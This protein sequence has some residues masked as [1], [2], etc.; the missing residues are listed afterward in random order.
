M[1]A[2]DGTFG[3]SRGNWAAELAEATLALASPTA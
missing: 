3:A 1:S 2:N